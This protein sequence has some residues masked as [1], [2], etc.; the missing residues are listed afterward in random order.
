MKFYILHINNSLASESVCVCVSLCMVFS[1]EL[2]HMVLHV[3]RHQINHCY[4]SSG[5]IH[6]GL[7]LSFACAPW[8]GNFRNLPDRITLSLELQNHST[9]SEFWG[10]NPGIHSCTVTLLSIFPS[11]RALS[12]INFV[13]TEV[14]F[15]L[16]QSQNT[17]HVSL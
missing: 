4:H 7:S 11:P 6:M 8:L 1:C 12:F 13:Y 3:C 2:V 16:L 14:W 15:Y 10:L 5:D 17:L 9:I